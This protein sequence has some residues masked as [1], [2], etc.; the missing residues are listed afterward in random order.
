[1]TSARGVG[2]TSIGQNLDLLSG[3]ASALESG[4]LK[5]Q[6]SIPRAHGLLKS[7]SRGSSSL[8]WKEVTGWSKQAK[9]NAC[10]KAKRREKPSKTGRGKL[11]FS[12][13]HRNCTKKGWKKDGFFLSCTALFFQLEKKVCS[14][15]KGVA[16]FLHENEMHS[17]VSFYISSPFVK[18]QF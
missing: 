1:M 5:Q 4:C 2:C 9:T 7:R 3:T 12:Y 14:A 13:Q 17:R 15:S 11:C 10:T 8:N 6:C 18:D 16:F